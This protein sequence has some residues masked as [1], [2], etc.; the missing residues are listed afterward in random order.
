LGLAT[1]ENFGLYPSTLRFFT[2][3][4]ES[5]LGYAY[6]TL[7]PKGKDKEV[8]GGRN[9]ATAGLQYDHRVL[10]DWVVAVFVDAGNAFNSTVDKIYY[11]SG[12]GVRW[13]SPFGSVRVDVAWPLNR[14]DDSPRFEEWRLHVG[15]GT[16]L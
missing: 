5:I 11:G 12:V 9:V 3:G 16:V 8:V 1:V 2:G 7:G 4:D 10:D 13:L 6:K 15:F 14:R